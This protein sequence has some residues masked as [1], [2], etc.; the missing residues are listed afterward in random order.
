MVVSMQMDIVHLRLSE[1][2]DT[3]LFVWVSL[4][5]ME[6]DWFLYGTNNKTDYN[7]SGGI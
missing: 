7:M 2:E 1:E 3:M 6:W 4:I 5:L